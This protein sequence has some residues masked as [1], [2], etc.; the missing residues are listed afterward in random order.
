M[1]LTFGV[2]IHIA[3]CAL[4]IKSNMSGAAFAAE[5]TVPFTGTVAAACTL[6]LDRAGVLDVNMVGGVQFQTDTLGK[7]SV[8]CP[9]GGS[10]TV[11][12]PTGNLLGGF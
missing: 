11:A 10:L 12:T 2:Q 7:I 1:H 4:H 6:T 8:D 9:A 5:V 3:Y